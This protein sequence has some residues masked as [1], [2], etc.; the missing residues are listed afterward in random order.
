MKEEAPLGNPLI[1]EPRGGRPAKDGGRA[2]NP[3][4]QSSSILSQRCGG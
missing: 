3:C 2:A 1:I 4:G